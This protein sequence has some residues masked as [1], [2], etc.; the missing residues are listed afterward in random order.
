MS[1]S[2]S[3]LVSRTSVM[4]LP[5]CLGWKILKGEGPCT[6]C[7]L[8]NTARFSYWE[9]QEDGQ[10]NRGWGRGDV[11]WQSRGGEKD[12][13]WGRKFGAESPGSQLEDWIYVNQLESM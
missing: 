7:K 11:C 13:S 10:K 8:C 4:I 5:A 2:L 12:R 6:V 9:R 1:V 3:I